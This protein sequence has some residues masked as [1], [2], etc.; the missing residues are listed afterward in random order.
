MESWLGRLSDA[1]VA[2]VRTIVIKGSGKCRFQSVASTSPP[3][4]PA[5]VTCNRSI[6]I[7]LASFERK[8]D[9]EAFSDAVEEPLLRRYR[10]EAVDFNKLV[11]LKGRGYVRMEAPEDGKHMGIACSRD[12]WPLYAVGA[13]VD[14]D[15]EVK[16]TKKTLQSVVW[17]LGIESK[18]V[19]AHKG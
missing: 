17:G 8:V 4:K 13:L 11:Y 3:A 14:D 10:S 2:Q 18:E 7:D 16:V 15:G 6:Y 9:K 19:V 1:Q 5:Q 12:Q